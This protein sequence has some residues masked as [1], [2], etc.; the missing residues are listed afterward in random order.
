MSHSVTPVTPVT[1]TKTPERNCRNFGFAEG[2]WGCEEDILPKNCSEEKT[3]DGN[4]CD[5]P[6]LAANARYSSFADE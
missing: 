4:G 6:S 3:A 2:Q 5:Q 1:I